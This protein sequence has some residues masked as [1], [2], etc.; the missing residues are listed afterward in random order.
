MSELFLD[1]NI[2]VYGFDHSD[3]AKQDKALRLLKDKPCISSQVIIETYMVC[4]R[5]L[6]LP[7]AKCEDITRL[8]CDITSI[9]PIQ[10]I[11]FNIALQLKTKFQFS[12]LDAVIVASALHANCATLYSEDM[13][14]G[15]VVDGK[16]T[17]VNPFI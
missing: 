12:F 4:S 8:L 6:K 16:L 2:C 1:T 11:V 10:S 7:P 15:L 5:K 3:V 13:Q 14:H 17:I 9:I